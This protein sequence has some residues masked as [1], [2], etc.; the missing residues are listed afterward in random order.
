MNTQ[1]AWATFRRLLVSL[2][3]MLV[4]LA[5]SAPSLAV[6]L[7]FGNSIEYVHPEEV[8][9]VQ[10]CRK[11]GI[12]YNLNNQTSNPGGG[13]IVRTKEGRIIVLYLRARN[14]LTLEQLKPLSKAAF[15]SR[16]NCP[17]WA[18]DK[19]LG[20][21][22][23]KGRF[24]KVTGLSIEGA[25]ITDA[26]LA[27]LKNFP[28]I[29]SLNLKSTTITDKG[30]QHLSKIPGLSF[31]RL[32]STG[33]TDKGVSYLPNLPL[34]SFLEL[35]TSQTTDAG[36]KHLGRVPK[37][38][39]LYLDDTSVNGGGIKHLAPLEHLRMLSLNNTPFNDRGL[40][41]LAEFPNL[42][43]LEVLYLANTKITDKG[44]RAFVNLNNLKVLTLAR[45]DT[46]DKS[47]RYLKNMPRLY[48]LGLGKNV[49]AEGRKWLA[50]NARFASTFQQQLRRAAG[51]DKKTRQKAMDQNAY[52][53]SLSGVE[54]IVFA[55]GQS[56]YNSRKIEEVRQQLLK[57]K[58]GVIGPILDMAEKSNEPGH[59][60]SKISKFKW[61]FNNSAS[62]LLMSVCSKHMPM[63]AEQYADCPRKRELI[64]RTLGR[65]KDD[66]TTH[67]EAW[68]EHKSRDVQI[69]ALQQLAR[70]ADIFRLGPG[71]ASPMTR[72]HNSLKLSQRAR[73][74][75]YALLP[76]GNSDVRRAASAVV[77]AAEDDVSTKAQALAQAILRVGNGAS[78]YKIHEALYHL[79]V[80]LPL[81]SKGLPAVINGF[82]LV[83][84][85]SNDTSDKHIAARQLGDLG[86]RSRVALDLLH[87]VRAGAD[88][89]LAA[90]AGLAL[91][92]IQRCPITFMRQKKIPLDV[93][94]LVFTLTGYDR[95]AADKASKELVR[96]GP[97]MV[98]PLAIAAQGET[99]EY[100]CQKAARIISQWEQTDILPLLRPAFKW[101]GK[102]VRLLV[103]YSISR[104]KWSELPD[105][106]KQ[107]LSGVDAKVR[108]HM[109]HSLSTL[110]A[111]T[112]GQ[113]SRDLARL[114]AAELKQPGMDWPLVSN[115]TRA[116]GSCYPA[117]NEVP[118]LLIGIAKQ[119]A[120][121]ASRYACD[122]LGT[123]ARRHLAG[124]DKSDDRKGIIKS[125]LGLLETTKDDDLK[126]SCM[127]VLA[128]FGPEAREALPVLRRIQKEGAS[129][130]ASSASRA[131][132][133]ID[134]SA[135][136]AK[137]P[138]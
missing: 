7:Q 97:K 86:G 128:R 24:P 83:L 120:K 84:Q 101:R 11:A 77:V 92:Q 40:M 89:K 98:L 73:K 87:S 20:F 133:S 81:D 27:G 57:T 111:N 122:A 96:R 37:L 118:S 125:M 23:H 17:A 131:I 104:M 63:L 28:F 9:A 109:R 88:D 110:A 38:H 69:V 25:K 79:A 52:R 33:I 134:R 103:I 71:A 32:N 51:V 100:Y 59:P 47:V 72:K 56:S 137:T 12:G 21:F 105:I 39:T 119:E 70:R 126:R 112:T 138:R 127:S 67:L 60:L 123:I 2:A 48:N 31:L 30:V 99:H 94:A 135:G 5:C 34:L 4:F 114:I 41:E 95:E 82:M 75:V 54:A 1:R 115:M 107:S 85:T 102:Y 8:E 44:C 35:K 68:L 80:Q 93:Q 42:A 90:T 132:A 16:F 49:T 66:L 91:D 53:A 136:P 62:Q 65:C 74:R 43:K 58:S 78:S 106:V 61:N 13:G 113:A 19:T 121:Y 6:E 15:L 10:Y 55:L 26:G 76:D 116:L 108:I 129:R 36:L 3:P 45:T 46:S 130:L 50:E 22:T 117:S 64:S 18:D 29:A 124:A 14:T